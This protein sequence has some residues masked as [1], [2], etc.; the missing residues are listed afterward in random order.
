MVDATLER[1]SSDDSAGSGAPAARALVRPCTHAPGVAERNPEATP[2]CPPGLFVRTSQPAHLHSWM[3]AIHNPA[4][5][6]LVGGSV[7]RR[8]AVPFP[9]SL[10][11]RVCPSPP[12][13]PSACHLH[14]SLSLCAS[15]WCAQGLL[16]FLA[17]RP[18]SSAV[19]T[20]SLPPDVEFLLPAT[21]RKRSRL[22]VKLLPALLMILPRLPIAVGLYSVCSVAADRHQRAAT[23][24]AHAP[25]LAAARHIGCWW[26][27][28]SC[29]SS[30]VSGSYCC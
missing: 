26:R 4:W 11:A 7:R 15:P 30:I 25:R 10:R 2:P 28:R 16:R 19:M 24:K 18:P 22:R 12:S 17:M 27:V 21:L 5:S 29:K 1:P 9:L 23:E 6:L 13:P 20:V 8:R 14:L 3:R